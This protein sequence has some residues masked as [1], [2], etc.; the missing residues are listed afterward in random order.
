WL[1]S[2]MGTEPKEQT[3]G[4]LVLAGVP[5]CTWSAEWLDT[6]KN[7]WIGR[8][9]ERSANGRLTLETPPI[10]GSVAVRLFRCGGDRHN[11]NRFSIQPYR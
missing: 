4:R 2:R 1:Y 11:R 10:R 3:S 5:T 7:E 9:V 6:L 8:T